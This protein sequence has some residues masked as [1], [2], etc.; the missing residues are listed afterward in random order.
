MRVTLNSKNIR[1]PSDERPYLNRHFEF[2]PSGKS[3]LTIKNVDRQNGW[4]V[5]TFITETGELEIYHQVW[6]GE[7]FELKKSYKC[8][9]IQLHPN[10]IKPADHFSFDLEI[11]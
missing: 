5:L 9:D 10:S 4:I 8:F 1:F 11:A 3:E 6:K 7:K 2:I